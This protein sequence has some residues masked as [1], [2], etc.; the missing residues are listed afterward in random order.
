M[1]DILREVFEELYEGQIG[2]HP[3]TKKER[4]VW[5][6]A[7]AV[8]G[9]NAVDQLV[10]AQSR[11]ISEGHYDAFRLGFRLGALLILELV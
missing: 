7:Q 6:K 5:D 1:Q 11:S 9:G 2:S 4:A 10:Y 3:L 8:L